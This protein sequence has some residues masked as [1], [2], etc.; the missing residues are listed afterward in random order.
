MLL[1]LTLSNLVSELH[2]RPIKTVNK[3]TLYDELPFP[4]VTVCNLNQFVS[5]RIPNNPTVSLE[6]KFVAAFQGRLYC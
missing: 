4:A 3:I 6:F 1:A 5:D 2:E